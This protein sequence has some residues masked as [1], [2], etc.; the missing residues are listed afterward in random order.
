MESLVTNHG[1]VGD[2][3][4][5]DLFV[6]P[7]GVHT[8]LKQEPVEKPP[9]L[10]TALLHEHPFVIPPVNPLCPPATQ[11]SCPCQSPS[12]DDSL[13]HPQVVCCTRGYA[14]ARTTHARPP[15]LPE[16][17][18]RCRRHPR[19]LNPPLRSPRPC[20]RPRPSRRPLPR[21]T[22]GRPTPTRSSRESPR[23]I[24]AG[25]SRCRR[26]WRRMRVMRTSLTMK[27]RAPVAVTST[28]T[29]ATAPSTTVRRP[30]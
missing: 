26:R 16:R 14:P 13:A 25:R 5:F 4:D 1:I 9:S 28:L 22:T 17:G 18:R 10:P 2:T 24:P 7:H 8:T 20:T 6:R 19:P 23:Q 27:M 30:A 29:M 21:P 15:C 12:P 11:S 3:A